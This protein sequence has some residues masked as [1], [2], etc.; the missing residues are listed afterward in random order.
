MK[1]HHL[2][3]FLFAALLASCGGSPINTPLVYEKNPQ[4]SW[5]YVEYF[6]DYYFVENK[7]ANNV[8]SVS[9]FQQ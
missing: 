6:G 2:L 7:N 9:L 1:K 4:Y 5:G 3:I 8:L